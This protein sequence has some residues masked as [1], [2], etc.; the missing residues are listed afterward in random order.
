MERGN[1][2]AGRRRWPRN[3]VLAAGLAAATILALWLGRY[4][5]PGFMPLSALRTDPLAPRIL[6]DLRLPRVVAALV[7]GAALA[8]SGVVMQMLFG[9]PLVEPG[10]VGVSQGAALGAALAIVV[11]SGQQWAVQLA[12]AAGGIAGL[13]AAYL[14][15]R[16]LRYGGWILRLVLAGIAVSA[17]AS[18][19]VG[20][21]KL[22]ADP[23]Q[24]LPELTFW[25]LGGLWSV[26]WPRLLPVLPAVVIGVAVP[27]A[28][29]WRL[30]LLSMDDRVSFTLGAAPG[31][32]RSLYLVAATVAVAAVVSIAGIV[33]WVG[34]IVPHPTRRIVGADA[35]VALPA[36]A[37]IG[38]AFVA[39]ADAVARTAIAGEIPLGIV[40]SLVGATA[41][42]ALMTTNAIRIE[43]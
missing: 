15:A 2:A 22:V 37:M 4:P 42:L 17:V 11:G 6:L 26:N 43:R 40:T 24:E 7:L 31:R 9:N 8:T 20:V 19:G 21:V 32:E 23:L 10:L 5:E 38:A 33:G 28:G 12:A 25:L 39:L 34:L 27:L 18:A 1:A 41:F 13:A 14:I 3:G 30:N 35:A 16:R 29:R 36:S